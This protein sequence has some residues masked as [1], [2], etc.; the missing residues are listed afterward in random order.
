[1][2][3]EYPELSQIIK[4]NCDIIKTGKVEFAGKIIELPKEFIEELR[5]EM[6]EIREELATILLIL[7]CKQ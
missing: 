3:N 5:S 2:I 7:E 4:E 1:M 6:I